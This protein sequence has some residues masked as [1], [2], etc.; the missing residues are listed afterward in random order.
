MHVLCTSVF[1]YYSRQDDHLIVY[2]E[3]ISYARVAEK[4]EYACMG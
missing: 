2:S 4:I 1:E 3:H